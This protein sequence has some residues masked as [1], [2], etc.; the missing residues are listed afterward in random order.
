MPVKQ[1]LDGETVAPRKCFHFDSPHGPKNEASLHSRRVARRQLKSRPHHLSL[2]IDRP[3]E[4]LRS[5]WTGAAGVHGDGTE[6]VRKREPRVGTG[7]H[8][9]F[10]TVQELMGGVCEVGAGHA[11]LGAVARTPAVGTAEEATVSGS[12]TGS[13]LD[14]HAPLSRT[15]PRE[16]WF[17]VSS[18]T[19]T[20]IRSD[21][22]REDTD[23]DPW[24]TQ[25]AGCGPWSAGCFSCS[26]R[27]RRRIA[28]QHFATHVDD[29]MQ[30]CSTV[31]FTCW[32]SRAVMPR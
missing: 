4:N 1:A 11:I 21:L 26:S 19:E 27:P 30:V 8:T 18:S 22:S 29:T 3:A 13:R 10:E 31:S 32:R 9:P 23:V 7:R 28:I 5:S 12:T 6:H 24:R 15:V 14:A 20:C 2:L 17:F 25:P 16:S